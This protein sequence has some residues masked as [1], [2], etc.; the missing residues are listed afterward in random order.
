MG[1]LAWSPEPGDEGLLLFPGEQDDVTKDK[2]RQ[3]QGKIT[4]LGL[5]TFV[6]QPFQHIV[7]WCNTPK[8]TYPLPT[9]TYLPT[10]Y[11]VNIKA[12][13][14][15]CPWWGSL[16]PRPSEQCGW[17]CQS[18]SCQMHGGQMPKSS[19]C[20]THPGREGRRGLGRKQAAEQRDCQ[21]LQASSWP[22]ACPD[23]PLNS[24][25]VKWWVWTK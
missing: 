2:E 18:K 17:F 12:H 22:W 10:F 25:S 8:G 6:T 15:A 21:T 4:L 16:Q 9:P 24:S 23:P 20:G 11:H 5:G 7:S 13:P 19:Y 1:L 3:K 14:S